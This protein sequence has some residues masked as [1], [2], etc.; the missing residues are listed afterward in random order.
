MGALGQNSV[1][2][3]SAFED[4][5]NLTTGI[6]AQNGHPKRKKLADSK[7]VTQCGGM[8]GKEL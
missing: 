3:R 8:K 7:K 2:S 6:G 5:S 4:K 1:H